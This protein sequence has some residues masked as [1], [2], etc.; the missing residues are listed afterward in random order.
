MDSIQI[1]LSVVIACDHDFFQQANAVRAVLE[2]FGWVRVQFFEFFQQRQVIDFLAGNY[3]DCDYVIWY[4]WGYPD[5][6][7]EDQLRFQVV[8]QKDDDYKSKTGWERVN[9]TLTP[10]TVAQ[11]VQNPKGT[12]ICGAIAGDVWSQP[13]LQTGFKA[14]IAPQ[15]PDIS[16][17]AETLFLTGFF[18]TLLVHHSDYITSDRVFTAAAAVQHAAAM[19]QHY[20]CGTRLFRYYD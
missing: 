12:L 14:V 10:S 3:P 7:T 1:H 5:S 18:Y 16:C 2:S 8:H 20:E 13:L 15:P 6:E 9:F 11:Y 19:D 17:N 4:G